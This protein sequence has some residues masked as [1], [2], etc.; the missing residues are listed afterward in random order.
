M[1][2]IRSAIAVSFLICGA[3][4]AGAAIVSVNDVLSS[5]GL[6]ALVVD[7][8]AS[9]ADDA[10]GAEN[11]AMWGFN[12]VQ[13]FTLLS[14]LA[15]DGGFVAAG[16]RVSSHMIFLNTA[17][18]G[19]TKHGTDGAG[20]VEWTF[21]GNILGVMSDK[22][23]KLEAASSGFL[24]AP[25]TFYP[26]A[27]NARGFESNSAARTNDFYTVSAIFGNVL[28][29]GMEVTEPGDWIRVITAAPTP[30]PLPAAAWMLLAGL[31]GL[32]AAGRRRA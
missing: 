4:Q 21:D 14:D 20:A 25:G 3:S 7:A 17:G 12:E 31:A 27:F 13:G 10:P 11:A 19:L 16:T 2:F 22:T 5:Q 28:E 1:S 23:G 6:P 15:V 26:G 9:V 18:N 8:P 24:G 29:V 30:V 32:A